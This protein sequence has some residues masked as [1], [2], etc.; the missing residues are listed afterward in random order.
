MVTKLA[1][2]EEVIAQLLKDYDEIQKILMVDLKNVPILP[3]TSTNTVST[4]SNVRNSIV[5]NLISILNMKATLL[6][7]LP[8]EE[9][10]KAV[11]EDID[12]DPLP[13]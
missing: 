10:D 4:V 9:S 6:Y 12:S 3:N 8:S 7:V 2:Q 5:V 13:F 1:T 11:P